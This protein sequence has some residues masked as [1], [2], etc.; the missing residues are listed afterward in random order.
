MNYLKSYRKTMEVPQ[1]QLAKK[2]GVSQQF[3]CRVENNEVQVSVSR[4]VDIGRVLQVSPELIF[5]RLF[6]VPLETE[7]ARQGIE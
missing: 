1:Y 3:I 5:P 4:A 7:L 6:H 2:L